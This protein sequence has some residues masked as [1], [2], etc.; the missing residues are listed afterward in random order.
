MY[1][2]YTGTSGGKAVHMEEI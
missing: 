1:M 2:N